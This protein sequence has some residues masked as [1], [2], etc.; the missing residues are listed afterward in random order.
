MSDASHTPELTLARL[1]AVRVAGGDWVPLGLRESL[2][3][4]WLALEGP[5]ERGRLALLLWPDSTPDAA[6][7]A[8]RQRL[9]QL[10]RLS[11]A[12]LVAGTHTLALASSVV[13]D[14]MDADT[15]LGD[16]MPEAGAALGDWL[17]QQRARR[18]HRL[19]QSLADLSAQAEALR[20]YDDALGHARELLADEPLSEDAHRRVIRLHYL[21]G[22]RPAALLAFDHCEQVLKHE[23]GVPPSPDTLALLA[24]IQLYDAV[25]DG[26]GLRRPAGTVPAAVLRPPHRVGREAAWAT[27]RQAC[28]ARGT[29]LLRGEAGMGKSRL[30]GDLAVAGGA[31][32]H[33]LL[34]T[35][36]PGDAGVPYAVAARWLR[37]LVDACGLVPEPAQRPL[38]A[39]LLPEWGDALPPVQDDRARLSRAVAQLLAGGVAQGLRAVLVDD[40]Q[41][42]DDASVELLQVLLAEDACAWVLAMRPAELG[43]AA[44]ALVDALQR[45]SPVSSV[46][47]SPLDV[48]EVGE[49][50]ASLS[51]EGWAGAPDAQAEALHRRTG[52]NPLFLLETV[53]AVLTAPARSALALRAGA[54]AQGTASPWP[55]APNV[56]RLIQQRL[57][58]LSPLALRVAR[59]AAVAG[60]DTGAA[61]VSHVL[62]L[63]PLDLAD[64]WAELEDAQVLRRGPQG[65]PFAHDLIA[66]AALA[67]VPQAVAEPLHAQVAAWLAGQGGEPM[68][69]AGHWLAARRPMDAAPFLRAAAVKAYAA[70]RFADAGRLYT[71]VGDLLDDSGDRRGAFDAWFQAVAAQAQVA[72]DEAVEALRD[73]MARVAE[74]D[75]QRAMVA[76]V[77]MVLLV[78][79]RQLAEAEAK[80]RE[81][82]AIAVRARL[83]EIEAELTYGL[84][85]LHW[86]RREVAEATRCAQHALRLLESVPLAQR[87]LKWHTTDLKLHNA[88][89]IFLFAAGRY[90]EGEVH[91]NEARSRGL[92]LDD[93]TIVRDVDRSMAGI[94]MEQGD[95]PRALALTRSMMAL[96]DQTTQVSSARVLC[97]SRRAEVL[98]V[99]GEMGEALSLYDRMAEL[100]EQ[101]R[102][103]E[104]VVPM[105]RRARVLHLLGRHDL[106]LRSLLA[107]RARDDLGEG[108]ERACVEATLMSIGEPG[109]AARVLEQTGE[110]PDFPLRAQV[111]CLA[112]PGCEPDQ[113][114]PLLQMSLA[115]AREHGAHGLWLS[116]QVRRAAALRRAG[117]RREA[118]EAAHAAWQRIEEGVRCT[119]A[120]PDLAAVL[121]PAL[122]DAQ[123]GLAQAVGL[124][125]SG[126]M[127][128]AAATLAPGWRENYL[129]RAPAL[130][131][132]SLRLPR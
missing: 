9:F 17:V 31:S 86:A 90:A 67:S 52:G 2:L 18:R 55:E 91:M 30:L 6:R 41:F 80:A 38:L 16:T 20:D 58:R 95:L 82:V 32:P 14:L 106:A 23:V 22:D 112:Q 83:P 132:L 98:V 81:G 65:A 125:A 115:T 84:V 129:S 104:L 12:A 119:E 101:G 29:V 54:D 69:I 39:R 21:A 63:Q 78:E 10:R 68:R 46:A 36:R 60:Q 28:D 131:A 62:G 1:P 7:N 111:F 88:L 109:D 40:L 19:R 92:A 3:L 73:A 118:A 71:Q 96:M 117:R 47:L 79:G 110:I 123:P 56:T 5:T 50:L 76:L 44:Q 122:A 4:A 93:L 61:L 59:C 45:A 66:E 100:C 64:A 108:M 72:V 53:K 127:Q 89:G 97:L 105:T 128:S 13:H 51:I 85:V 15:V 99:Q 120:L 8:L 48:D 107:L 33:M 113:V 25:A 49:L 42:A 87:I 37:T 77:S 124:R 116:L 11:G 75:G 34:V 114:L 27:L 70:W 57:M 103:Y 130:Q 35:A 26:R 126:W 43:P 102:T 121:V 24:T 94:A 74:D